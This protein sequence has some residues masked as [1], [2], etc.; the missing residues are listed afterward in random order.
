MPALRLESY[1]SM[2]ARF[3][4]NW[5]TQYDLIMAQDRFQSV[6]RREVRPAPRDARTGELKPA[7][8]A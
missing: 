3:W 4:M 8:T 1:F 7:A 2:S 6:I 5:Q